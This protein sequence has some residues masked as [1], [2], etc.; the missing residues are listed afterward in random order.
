MGNLN[1]LQVTMRIKVEIKKKLE[2]IKYEDKMC[3]ISYRV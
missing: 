3:I 2:Q 1:P